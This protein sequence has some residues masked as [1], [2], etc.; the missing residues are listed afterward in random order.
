MGEYRTAVCDICGSEDKFTWQ[1]PDGWYTGGFCRM[2]NTFHMLYE[3]GSTMGM[4]CSKDC[5]K[6]FVGSYIG[7]VNAS[8]M[9]QIDDYEVVA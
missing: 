3:K 7:A 2:E 4:Y 1:K 6:S 8:F 5:L 9:K